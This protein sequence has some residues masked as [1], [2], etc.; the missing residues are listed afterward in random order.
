MRDL[1]AYAVERKSQSID[2]YRQMLD[3]EWE[4]AVLYFSLTQAANLLNDR[5]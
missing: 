5:S 2:S 1:N 4:N 3:S